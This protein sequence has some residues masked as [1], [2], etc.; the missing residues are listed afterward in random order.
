MKIEEED[1]E[2]E[3]IWD[4]RLWEIANQ[5]LSHED[6]NI[7]NMALY[8]EGNLNLKYNNKFRDSD[9]PIQPL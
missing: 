1:K 7:R 6:R 9:K 8:V 3:E 2:Q 4:K 5:Y